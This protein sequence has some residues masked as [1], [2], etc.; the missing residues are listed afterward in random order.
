M[1]RF[2]LKAKHYIWIKGC[3]WEHKEVSDDGRQVRKMYDVPMY[4]DPEQL[5][6]WNGPDGVYVSTREDP[7]YPRD[8]ILLGPCTID[9]E[10]LDD[11]A[12]AL[13]DKIPP[14]EHPIDSLPGTFAETLMDKLSKQVLAVGAQ[15]QAE[16]Q[17]GAL[18]RQVAELKALV[19]SLAKPAGIT[20]GGK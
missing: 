19:M 11:E 3:Q 10:P 2:R 20:L 17:V 8:H 9:M 13:R 5:G 12:Q 1:A 16:T 15:A 18:E 14:G 6:D 7:K 4:L